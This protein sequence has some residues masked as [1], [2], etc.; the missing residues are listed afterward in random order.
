VALSAP[1]Y[2]TRNVNVRCVPSGLYVNPAPITTGGL[3]VWPAALDPNTLQPLAF[4]NPRGGLAPID[5]E[6]V[7]PNPALLTVSPA[8]VSIDQYAVL[9]PQTGYQNLPITFAFQLSG[10]AS[11]DVA[12]TTASPF[13]FV[14]SNTAHIRVAG[15]ALSLYVPPVARDLMAQISGYFNIAGAAPT[16]PVPMTFTTSDPSKVLLT[17]NPYVDGQASITVTYVPSSGSARP[18]IEVLDTSGSVSITAS[19]PG[20]D[21]VTVP[22]TF[23]PLQAGFFYTSSYSTVSNPVSQI[24]ILQGQTSTVAI[25][26]FVGPINVSNG[27]SNLG[28]QLRPGANPIQIQLSDSN[29]NLASTVEPLVPMSLPFPNALTL[30]LQAKAPG[31]ATFSIAVV[32][33]HAVAAWPLAVTVQPLG[34][35]LG[36][37]SVGYGLMAPVSVSFAGKTDNNPVNLKLTV[38]DPSLALLSPDTQTPGQPAL[39]LSLSNGSYAAA[40][41]QSLTG[42]SRRRSCRRDSPGNSP[43]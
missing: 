2:P 26:A 9:S 14:P 1:G 18:W 16:G 21:P 19:T 41:L 3:A 7:N 27:Y 4:Q 15:P 30:N 10:A 22:V 6:A 28:Y 24:E 43:R 37:S 23:S 31:T 11:I 42:S 5:I 20:S 25:S 40:Y 39:N 38:S 8:A 36:V 12:F 35:N 33:G 17:D 32:S 13:G 29:F 34:L